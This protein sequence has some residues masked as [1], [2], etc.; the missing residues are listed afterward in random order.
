MWCPR[1]IVSPPRFPH[2]RRGGF[3]VLSDGLGILV[4]M[5]ELTEHETALLDLE[6]SWWKYPAAKEDAVLAQFGVSMTRY[7]QQLNALID[8]PEALEHDPLTVKRLRRLRDQRRAHRQAVA[9]TYDVRRHALMGGPSLAEVLP[10]PDPETVRK[11]LALLGPA[12]WSPGGHGADEMPE[13][14]NSP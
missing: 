13:D 1:F 10:T 5:T 12:Y 4:L 6:R 9:A 8:R 11:I 14:D 2:G 3:V 7:Y